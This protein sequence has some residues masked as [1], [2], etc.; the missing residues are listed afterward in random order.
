MNLLIQ[1]ELED[2]DELIRET[3]SE[4]RPKRDNV[5]AGSSS[6]VSGLST[7]L[8]DSPSTASSGGTGSPLAQPTTNGWAVAYF[9]RLMRRWHAKQHS[10]AT[11]KSDLHS[12]LGMSR[13]LER[14]AFHLSANESA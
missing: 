13:Q 11:D 1:R 8:L 5:G 14:A 6:T 2:F 12:L 10:A 4:R 7:T 3:K 9:G